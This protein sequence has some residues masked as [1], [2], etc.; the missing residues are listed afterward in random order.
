MPLCMTFSSNSTGLD[1]SMTIEWEPGVDSDEGT[2]V[3][4]ELIYYDAN[5]DD[6]MYMT[7]VLTNRGPWRRQFGGPHHSG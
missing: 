7:E 6:P 3:S 2:F 5:L 1:G 4:I